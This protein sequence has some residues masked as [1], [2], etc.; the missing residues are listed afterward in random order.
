MKSPVKCSRY[1]LKRSLIY[2]PSKFLYTRTSLQLRNLFLRIKLPAYQSCNKSRNTMF[3]QRT[4]FTFYDLLSRSGIASDL[5]PRLEEK[6][7]DYGIL[8]A[9]IRAAILK[10]GLEDIDGMNFYCISQRS[11]V[12]IIQTN[13]DASAFLKAV[14]LRFQ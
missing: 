3:K 11:V 10:M 1:F 5:F 7:V 8:E 9:E 2:K 4:L 14:K 13:S 12:K 6:E